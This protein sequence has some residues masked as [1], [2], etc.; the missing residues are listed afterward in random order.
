MS[1]PSP[2]ISPYVSPTD[3]PMDSTSTLQ[4]MSL[5]P[6]SQQQTT[7]ANNN[8]FVHKLFNMVIDPHYQHLISWNYTDASFIVCNIVEF[9]R[10]VLP[11]HFKHNNFS[12][13]VRQLNMYGFHKVNKS[14]R[15]HRT[16]AE[17]QIWEF[18]HPKF[19]RD[20]HDLL[21][22]IKRKALETDTIRRDSSDVGSHLSMMQMT[23]SDIMQKLGRL[24]ENF[25]QV[26]QEL[27][28]TKQRQ[29]Q[30]QEMMK[31]MMQVL[32]QRQGA[33]FHIPSDFDM[34]KSTTTTDQTPSILI[35]SPDVG[36]SN[37][38]EN[39]YL[40]LQDQH[41]S[42]SFMQ[43]PIL[44]SQNQ[45]HQQQQHFHNNTK[46]TLRRTTPLTVQ[47]QN[48]SSTLDM[49][50]LGDGRSPISPSYSAY[51]TPLSSTPVSPNAFLS[52][53]DGPSLYSPHSPHTPNNI[54]SSQQQ[55]TTNG[56][57][58]NQLPTLQQHQQQQLQQHGQLLP[59]DAYSFSLDGGH[60][61]G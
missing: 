56:G 6:P 19:M 44:S 50:F 30:Q 25:N 42:S 22:E 14:P 17:N 16:L 2:T 47:T 11:K 61:L 51:H 58:M 1:S 32:S 35:T 55:M 18:S 15:G 36:N 60:S 10:D 12:S 48:L 7:K 46:Q 5:E 28:E 33:Q 31:T 39:Y 23:Q 53:D 52:D 38:M 4:K 9:S 34:T 37:S 57:M 26:V 43:A 3:S 27:E 59:N 24:Q 21:D 8:T 54:G 45:H 40:P 13:F 20:R 29:A 41:S 49:T